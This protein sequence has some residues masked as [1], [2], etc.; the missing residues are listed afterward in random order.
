M[1]LDGL[2][3]VRGQTDGVG[4]R[5]TTVLGISILIISLNLPGR[6]ILPVSRGLSD[7]GKRVSALIGVKVR[8]PG[9]LASVHIAAATVPITGRNKA[10]A[11]GLTQI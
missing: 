11:T 7:F 4:R 5:Q 2:A 9:K 1:H 3:A 10:T 6:P 8:K